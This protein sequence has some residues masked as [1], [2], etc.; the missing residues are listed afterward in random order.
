MNIF[1]I[2][3]TINITNYLLELKEKI[4]RLIIR[5]KTEYKALRESYPIIQ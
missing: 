2:I 5:E 3:K 4:L 1:H